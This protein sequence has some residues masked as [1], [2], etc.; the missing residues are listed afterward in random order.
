MRVAVEGADLFLAGDVGGIVGQQQV[1][2]A[3]VGEVVEY[4]L[5]AVAVLGREEAVAQGVERLLELGVA[6]VVGPGVVAGG[7]GLRDC[8]GGEAEDED[9]LGADLVAKWTMTVSP[10]PPSAKPPARARLPMGN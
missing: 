8:V 6:V 10:P 7:V 2:V 3:V 5:V 9:V 1:V 4:G